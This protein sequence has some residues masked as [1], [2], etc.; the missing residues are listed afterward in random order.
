M[1]RDKNESFPSILHEVKVLFMEH[2]NLVYMVLLSFIW[3]FFWSTILEYSMLLA[4]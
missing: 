1:S 4:D 3:K 2:I